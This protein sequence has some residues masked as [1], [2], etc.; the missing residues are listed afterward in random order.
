[1][2]LNELIV[3]RLLAGTYLK[4]NSNLWLLTASGYRH[5]TDECEVPPLD[6]GIQAFLALTLL[7][8]CCRAIVF[9]SSSIL[10]FTYMLLSPR[11]FGFRLVVRLGVIYP[12]RRPL[13]VV[14]LSVRTTAHSFPAHGSI[15]DPRNWTRKNGINVL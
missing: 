3:H 4:Q 8:R 5:A 2:P 1:M 7:L 12:E 9:M 15:M 13:L 10:R 6:I 11:P 14:I